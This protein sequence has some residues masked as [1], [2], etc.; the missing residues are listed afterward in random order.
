MKNVLAFAICLLLLLAST[1]NGAAQSNWKF[2]FSQ[3]VKAKGIIYVSRGDIYDPIKGYGWEPESWL[4][5]SAVS[6][7]V[8][9]AAVF[10]PLYFSVNLPEGNYD[11]KLVLGDERQ[12]TVTT[13]K[14]ENRRLMLERVETA[15]GKFSAEWFTVHVRDSIIRPAKEVVRLK[16]GERDYRHWD[17]KLTIEFNNEAPLIRQLEIL[18][19][20]SSKTIFLAGNSTVVDQ[21]HEPWA[22]WGQMIP[23]FFVPHKIAVANYAE[24]GETLKAFAREKRLEK[25]WSRAQPGDYLFIEF[26]HN[27]QKPGGNHLD[28]FTSYKDTLRSWIAAAKSRRVAPVLV[29]SMHRRSFDSTGKINNTLGDYPEA[30]R[31]V[32][33]EEGTPLI[34]L[35]AMS[36]ILYEAW[37]PERSLKAFVH[38]PA[39]SFPNQPNELK[40]NTHFTSYGAYELASCV[41]ME[42]KRK[43]PELAKQLRSPAFNFDPAKP[44][45]YENWTLPQSSVRPLSKPDGN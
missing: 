5:T 33:A 39:N 34:D 24:S 32:A 29:T 36:K 19:N 31:Q 20:N 42:I 25:I 22:A 44:M 8:T 21:A 15:P 16:P 1:M 6:R 10:K 3:P 11:M 37:G 38:F 18:P 45:P 14:V 26:T 12:R 43:I 41:V 7:T 4:D 28:A 13:V 2:S 35:N 23:A 17:N 30:M 27:D 9:N 40:D